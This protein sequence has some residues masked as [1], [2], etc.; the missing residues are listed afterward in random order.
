MIESGK[1]NDVTCENKIGFI[2]L[3]LHI[4][5]HSD[6]LDYVRKA[7]STCDRKKGSLEVAFTHL[8]AEVCFKF[9][10]P[11]VYLVLLY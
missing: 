3:P 5:M 1:A 6:P 4:A 2:L 9:F 10:G 7:K 8:A 11:K